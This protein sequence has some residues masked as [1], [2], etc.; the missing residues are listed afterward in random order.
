[1][2]VSII[3]PHRDRN[4]N[5]A[6]CLWSLRRAVDACD[7]FTHEIIVVDSHSQTPP[8]GDLRTS[9]LYDPIPKGVFNKPR[10]LN[11][12]IEAASGDLLAFLDADTIVPRMWF[13]GFNLLADD[14]TLTRLCYRVRYLPND[15]LTSV[16]E[17]GFAFAVDNA[18][19]QYDATKKST[20]HYLYRIGHEGTGLPERD[21]PNGYP[22][23]GNSQFAM[24][25]D[26]LGRLRYNED[27]EG[28]SYEDLWFIREIWKRNP[29]AYKTV[30]LTDPDRAIFHIHNNKGGL[31]WADPACMKRNS[32][33]YHRSWDGMKELLMPIIKKK[34][35]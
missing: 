34:R 9:V 13:C 2:K 15:F 3:I 16:D 5:L 11:I 23:F 25:R 32:R 21:K 26:V 4:T 1:M 35:A 17:D 8:L 27:Y 14:P 18:F 28:R 30:L 6:H 12:G 22:I 29:D 7:S 10:C 19:A 31:D 20:C 24:R 33:A